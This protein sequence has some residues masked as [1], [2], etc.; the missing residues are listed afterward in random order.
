MSQNTVSQKAKQELLENTREYKKIRIIK[1]IFY[2]AV[3]GVA[4]SFLQYYQLLPI[5]IL[6]EQIMPLISLWAGIGSLVLLLLSLFCYATKR[7]LMLD[8]M[9]L[10]NFELGHPMP[11][12]A[13]FD[14][15]IDPN[16]NTSTNGLTD[17]EQS[18]LSQIS[19]DSIIFVLISIVAVYVQVKNGAYHGMQTYISWLIN[20]IN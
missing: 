5:S 9:A 7:Q 13:T 19:K 8:V 6:P 4:L 11:E 2:I 15:H 17:Q 16:S 14:K 12:Q 1:R 20:F 10:N 3:I 18:L